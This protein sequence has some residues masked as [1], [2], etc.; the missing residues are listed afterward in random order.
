MTRRISKGM[1]STH[2]T[3]TGTYF[4]IWQTGF[5]KYILRVNTRAKKGV[6]RDVSIHTSCIPKYSI[7]RNV[8]N[9]KVEWVEIPIHMTGNYH[10]DCVYIENILLGLHLTD[11]TKGPSYPKHSF[12]PSN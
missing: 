4:E 7:H 1:T 9:G 12:T 2:E 10:I 3:G 11:T 8:Y 5:N 6:Y